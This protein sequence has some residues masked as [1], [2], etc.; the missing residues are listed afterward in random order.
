MEIK[1]TYTQD[2]IDTMGFLTPGQ[3]EAY[4]ESLKVYIEAEYPDA[5]VEVSLAHDDVIRVYA[6]DYDTQMD[7]NAEVHWL[8]ED[9]FSDWIEEAAVEQQ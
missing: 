3:V 2:A 4:G 7:V 1:V 8:I 5:D 6:D 9:H